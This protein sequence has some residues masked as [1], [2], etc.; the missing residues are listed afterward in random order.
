M[1]F[2]KNKNI[3]L[4][5]LLAYVLIGAAGCVEFKEAKLY[6]G[7]EP[8]EK[9]KLPADIS[10]IVEPK[11]FD[12]ATKDLWGLK[13]DVCQDA[14]IDHTIPYKGNDCIKLSWNREAEGC[15]FAGIGIGWD[16]YAGK[17]LSNLMNVAAIQFYVRTISGKMYGLPFVLTLEDYSG[18][19]GFCYTSNKY[20]ERSAIDEKWQRVV[21]PL[22][23]FDLEIENLDPSNIKQLQIELQQSGN[24]YLDDI[25][26]VYYTPE[27]VIPWMLEEVLP[28]PLAMPVSIFND[29][30]INDNSWGLFSTDCHK[31]EIS[32]NEK[33]SGS[34]SIHAKW[35]FDKPKCDFNYWGASWNKWK[36]VDMTSVINSVA[37]NFEIKYVG[38]ASQDVYA[39]LQD[40][41]RS[42]AE[43]NLKTLNLK[44]NVWNSVSIPLNSLPQKSINFEK[45][46]DFVMHFEGSG[47]VYID[48]IR[49]VSTQP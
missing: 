16:N 11:I 28:D 33:A 25:K 3:L 1:K 34:K 9:F 45:V 17:D 22:A 8:K 2:L 27:P 26:L 14:S 18:G 47:E 35:D 36:P 6:D 42:K 24:V 19:M 44:P 49:L 43:I 12:D 38:S 23:D 5:S 13:K 39:G 21:V 41:D 4:A 46:K 37:I 32:F 40:Y 10:L 15:K 7:V 30:F 20:F 29:A 48:D 31:V